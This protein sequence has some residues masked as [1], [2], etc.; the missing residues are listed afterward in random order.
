M[1]SVWIRFVVC[2]AVIAIAGTR[3]TK[4]GDIIAT[5]TGLGGLWIGL[6]LLAI[7]TSLPELFTGISAVAIVKA[8]DLTIGNLLGAC[9]FCLLNLALLDIVFRSDSP[10]LTQASRTHRLSAGLSMALVAVAVGSIFI[11]L[12][13]PELGRLGWVG[14]YTPIII[15]LYLIVMR[16]VFNYE[17]G[18]RVQ[19]HRDR[20]ASLRYEHISLGRTYLYF[21]IATVF[22][23]GAGIWL[24]TI[25][26]DI[27]EATG[28]GESF[29]GSLFLAFT[30]ALPEIMVSY[31]ALRLG[32]VD[33]CIAN[34]I[35]SNLFDITIIGIVDLIYEQPILAAVL[36]PE[37]HIVIGIAVLLMTGILIAGLFSR[38]RGKTPL[39]VT[40]Y[41]P[42][43][44]VVFIV[45]FY[46]NFTLSH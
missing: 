19:T 4:Y 41:A 40:W 10:L 33:M 17:R 21:A 46:L 30:T 31:S 32:A 16:V 28:W 39:R 29:V 26:E 43:M 13:N 12:R 27:A 38:P 8:P 1:I 36:E 5:K 18:Q 44:V 25:G 23:I 7:I 11:S 9:A 3:L 24:A 42:L 34:L 22:V 14:I 37:S 6:V 45:G 35:G 20:E 15:L 2:V